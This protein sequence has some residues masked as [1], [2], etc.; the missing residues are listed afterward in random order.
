MT[1]VPTGSG[2]GVEGSGR[3]GATGFLGRRVVRH[4]LDRGFRVRAVAR[5]LERVPPL[6]GLNEV[7]V[8][9]VGADVHDDALVA[10]ALADA[11]GALNAVS[12]YVQ[13]GGHETFRAVH[14]EAAA[15]VAQL[16]REAGLAR[17]IHVSGIGADLALSSRRR[18]A[19]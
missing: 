4:L 16:A 7:G 2:Q 12:L 8:E 11:E 18:L 13:R 3:L 17:L 5:H 10:T 6:F 14:V 15:R 9:A 1:A 19:C